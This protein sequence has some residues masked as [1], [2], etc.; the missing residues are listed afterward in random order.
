MNLRAFFDPPLSGREDGQAAKL[1][2]LVRLRWIALCAQALS[3]LPGL[4]F[5]LLE[6]GLLPVFGAIV[7]GLALLNAL[8]WRA[9]KRGP[10]VSQRQ[11]LVQLAADVGALGAL[12][13]LTGGAWNPLFPLLFFHAGLGGLLLEGRVSV[14]FV[15]ILMGCIVAVQALSH[16]PPGLA[17]ARVEPVVLFPAQLLVA[18]L[19]YL[20]S[21][22]LS[23]TLTSLLGHAHALQ[24][25][26]VRFDRLRAIGA[27]AAGLSHE[28][29]TPL[30]TAMLKLERL[31]RKHGLEDSPELADASDELERCEDV[32]RHMAGS[33]LRPEGLR[34]EVVDLV[35]LAARVCESVEG[36]ADGAKL[37]LRVPLSATRLA[38]SAPPV[39]LTQG[40]LNL[41]DNARQA[42]PPGAAVELEVGSAGDRAILQVRDR[43]DGWPEVVREHLGEPFVTTRP[44]GVGLGL[45]YVWTLVTALGGELQLDD[46]EGGGA[47]ARLDLPLALGRETAG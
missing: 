40:L 23:R 27:L 8:T 18:T 30:N 46:R 37:E 44:H 21:S 47:C 13:A 2:W 4:H 20:L 11:L 16:I 33:Q 17:E 7:I 28:L 14:E 26:R 32:L 12:L 25:H 9:L 5:G 35:E 29:A 6:P 3:V 36:E 22:W 41:I 1:A 10:L 39:A 24:E 15:W 31:G 43:G 42:S 19:F 45:Y 34:M 38:V